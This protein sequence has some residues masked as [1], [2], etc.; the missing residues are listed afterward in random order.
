[1]TIK[2]HHYH[3]YQFPK[4]CGREATHVHYLNIGNI[5][6]NGEQVYRIR[7]YHYLPISD[8]N[9]IHKNIYYPFKHRNYLREIGDSLN[10]PRKIQHIHYGKCC[11]YLEIPY[12]MKLVNKDDTYTIQSLYLNLKNSYQSFRYDED[13]NENLYRSYDMKHHK[14]NIFFKIW[15]I[16]KNVDKM[17]KNKM[18]KDVLPYFDKINWTTMSRMYPIDDKDFVKLYGNRINTS[19]AETYQIGLRDHK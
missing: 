12:G 7:H 8:D 2:V 17:E 18:E 19:F 15:N 4:N 14:I 9:V 11:S 1:M 3:F 10:S 13:G 16:Y 5:L 6:V